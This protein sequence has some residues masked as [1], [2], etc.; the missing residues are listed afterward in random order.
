[1]P[2]GQMTWTWD[3]LIQQPNSWLEIRSLGP[4][5]CEG[6]LNIALNSWMPTLK[7]NQLALLVHKHSGV[8]MVHVDPKIYC[9]TYLYAFSLVWE[10]DSVVG[11][12][13]ITDPRGSKPP[14]PPPPN[15]PRITDH[16]PHKPPPPPHCLAK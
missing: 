9:D 13:R 8:A 16:P 1:M 11:G 6:L 12:P 5:R 15:D 2:Y 7:T 3:H 10:V 4:E 14:P